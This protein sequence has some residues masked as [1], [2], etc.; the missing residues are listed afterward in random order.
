MLAAY[1]FIAIFSAEL[2]KPK[3]DLISRLAVCSKHVQS[4]FSGWTCGIK[5]KMLHGYW[6]SYFNRRRPCSVHKKPLINLK[7]TGESY[8]EEMTLLV[9]VVVVKSE[10]VVSREGA[11][12]VTTCWLKCLVRLAHYGKISS[13]EYFM[14]WTGKPDF[15]WY[16]LMQQFQSRLQL[17][18]LFCCL[19][20]SSQC[21]TGFRQGAVQITGHSKGVPKK[22]W[23]NGNNKGEKK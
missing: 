23:N 19:L 9:M 14:V 1:C 7:L 5:I 15:P 11:T 22:Q 10:E 12:G 3:K 17:W 2:S 6:K 13:N 4:S 21:C 20:F 18:L 16:A 8:T